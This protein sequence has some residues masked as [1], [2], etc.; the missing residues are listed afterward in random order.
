MGMMTK[1]RD[2]AHVFIIAFAVVFIAF[3]V[4]SDIDIGSVMRGSQNEVG[5]INGRSVTL[6]EYQKAIDEAIKEEQKKNNGKELE[7]NAVIQIREQIWD[8]YVLLAVLEQAS[9]DL[10]L[11][12]TD[13]EITAAV[14]SQNPPRAIARFFVDS[15]GFNQEKYE[16][17]LSNPGP[18]NREIL[19]QIENDIRYELMQER[20]LMILS[21]CTM[22]SEQD[23][24]DKFANESVQ[25]SANY[26]MFDPNVIAAKDTA[27]PSDDEYRSWYELNKKRFKTEET[28]KIKYV[29]FP[30]TPSR[31]DSTMIH[32][33]LASIAEEAR[34]GKDFL[35]L[36]KTN[37]DQPYNENQ[38]FNHANLAPQVSE[39][40]FGQTVG[41]IVGPVASEAGYSI[42][43]I[44]DQRS[45]EKTYSEIWHIFYPTFSGQNDATQKGKAEDA[46]RQARAGG[47]FSALA[48]RISEDPSTGPRRGYLGWMEKGSPYGTDFDN[49]VAR[50]KAG[51]VVGPVKSQY[52]YHVIKVTNRSASEV[53]IAEI[54]M[55]VKM[56]A[57]TRSDIE[58]RARDFSYFAQEKGI[59]E[60]AKLDNF[61]VEESTE[62]SRSGGVNTVIPGIG[63]NP[64][65]MK[66]CFENSVGTTSD[67]YE[68]TNGFVVVKITGSRPEGYKDVEEVKDQITAEVILDRK[69]RKTLEFAR[70]IAQPG[71]SLADIAAARPD[72]AVTPTGSFALGTGPTTIGRDDAF[73]G[74]LLAMQ[75]GQISRPFR[76]MMGVFVVQLENK[77]GFNE[78]EYKV[79]KDQIR[80]QNGEQLRTEFVNVWWKDMRESLSITDNRDRFYR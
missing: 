10:D 26:V 36:V 27:K 62:F 33:N 22:M 12:V 9:K 63:A 78:T 73:V 18:E 74:T 5:D 14:R 64:M 48:G 65:L 21:A 44:M 67:V 16:Q 37:S 35:E 38:W 58:K 50:A 57:R 11:E 4:I 51:E 77:T 79:K 68:S 60:E 72:L 7:N 25:L 3:W 32:D 80:Q 15:T 54:R 29:L 17:F 55:P 34:N 20:L 42:Y 6:Q 23:L 24:R 49:A 75:P 31:A 61:K 47:D 66:F 56:G 13:A 40:V 52:G 41:S 19:V 76:G 71:K 59:D 28:R 1:M 8:Q 69:I 45:G 43:K 53:R 30:F 2:N 39:V 46:L 70:S